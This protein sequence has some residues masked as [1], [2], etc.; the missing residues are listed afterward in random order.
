MS[1]SE[2]D[3]GVYATAASNH[4]RRRNLP[5]TPDQ[6]GFFDA[7]GVVEICG[8]RQCVVEFSGEF[9][10]TVARDA[11]DKKIPLTAIAPGRW[12]PVSILSSCALAH[13]NQAFKVDPQKFRFT[14]PGGL[15][16]LKI[17][18]VVGAAGIRP[19]L[20]MKGRYSFVAGGIADPNT[21]R[22]FDGV[23]F[24]L[25]TAGMRTWTFEQI[26]SSEPCSDY[27]VRLSLRALED[28]GLVTVKLGPRGGMATAKVTWT[29]RAYLPAPT[30]RQT[31]TDHDD[32]L[33]LEAM[34]MGLS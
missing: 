14:N 6:D 21:V 24:E 18:R 23:G 16:E 8:R 20:S 3:F 30:L 19:Y 5:P 7:A 31:P 2:M 4:A 17:A 11:E 12:D 9:A 34:A 28:V 10:A 25:P 33:A 22:A 13:G 32:D 27:R 29:P 15:D 26:I 1:Q